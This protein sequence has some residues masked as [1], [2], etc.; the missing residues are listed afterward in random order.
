MRKVEFAEFL[1][2]EIRE[3]IPELENAQMWLR[4]I[5]KDNDRSY[6]GLTIKKPGMDISPTFNMDAMY[7][8]YTE[9]EDMLTI[10]DTVR[11]GFEE[12]PSLDRM[13]IDLSDY[14][15]V[16][17]NITMVIRE[18]SRCQD[19]INDVPY[20]QKGEF[21]GLFKME[22][23]NDEAAMSATINNK[24]ME[25]YGVNV[26]QLYEQAKQ[27]DSIN[28]KPGLYKMEE[29]MADIF[30]DEPDIVKK[31]LL[32][33]DE[34]IGS[35][36]TM[37]V[38][39][40]EEKREGAALLLDEGILEKI[41]KVMD[42]GYYVIPSS[43]HE[44]IIV[45]GFG[46]NASE[47]NEMIENVNEFEIENEDILSN[48]SQYYDPE[49]KVLMDALKYERKQKFKDVTYEIITMVV[50][51]KD[52]CMDIINDVPYVEQGEFIGLFKIEFQRNEHESY[53]A[54]ISNATLEAY[55][56]TKDE[57]YDQAKENDKKNTYKQPILCDIND[58]IFNIIAGEK[59]FDEKNL[60]ENNEIINIE[61]DELLVLSNRGSREGA[62]LLFNEDV[63]E[64]ISE[65]MNGD[66]YIIPSS[67]H[68]VIVLKEMPAPELNQMIAEVNN[69]QVEPEDVLSYNAQYY[70]SRNKTLVNALSHENQQK[71]REMTGEISH[72][73]EMRYEEKARKNLY[74]KNKEQKE[75]AK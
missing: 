22:F 27:N 20:I 73:S 35:D 70:D 5:Q 8:E 12:L 4:Y 23:I 58:I 61:D 28:K 24:I 38:L 21:I 31:N 19:I 67:I 29:V 25:A 44:A 41:S 17:N 14:D 2:D 16:K 30:I 72:D 51:S 54:L 52:R 56:I 40:N 59:L 62:A 3:E 69:T 26:E 33:S 36:Q 71:F 53:A 50:R 60:L 43:I 47:L 74:L 13:G 66:Y 48:N 65:V 37:L 32:K 34:V 11:A 46:M 75:R 57:L 7:K 63:L 6:Y 55:G 68:E 1:Q 39:T 18:K 49:E 9:T 15:S 45:N 64:R 42:G 10:M